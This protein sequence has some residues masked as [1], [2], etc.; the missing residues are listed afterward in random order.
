LDLLTVKFL[1]NY[2]SRPLQ[3]FGATGVLL[4]ATGFGLGCY[5]TW[6][7]YVSDESIM[8]RPLL[9]LAVLLMVGGLQLGSLGLVGELITRLY[10]Q[11]RAQPVYAIREVLTSER[12]HGPD[13]SGPSESS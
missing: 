9:F 6:I 13:A 4:G 5:L 3:I 8:D 12:S 1:L 10:H 2:S 11:L 7:K